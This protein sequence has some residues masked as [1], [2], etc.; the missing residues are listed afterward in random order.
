MT[1]RQDKICM[2]NDYVIVILANEAGDEV[3]DKVV[4]FPGQEPERIEHRADM[5]SLIGYKTKYVEMPLENFDPNRKWDV[6]LA[7]AMAYNI[8]FD[9][10]MLGRECIQNAHEHNW[11]IKLQNQY[12]LSEAGKKMI[13]LAL[14][15]PDKA[16][17]IWSS[18]LRT[19]R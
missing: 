18:L 1:M 2:L 7:Y 10:A 19:Q 15:E 6:F 3:F 17:E 9:L 4:Y 13:Q 16:K 14:R 12:H 8:P 11:D 5:L